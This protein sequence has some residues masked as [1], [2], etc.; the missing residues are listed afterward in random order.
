MKVSEVAARLE[1]LGSSFEQFQAAHKTG[2]EAGQD[3]EEFNTNLFQTIAEKSTFKE[4]L[5]DSFAW[6]RTEEGGVYW[7][8]IKNGNKP[9]QV[10]ASPDEAVPDYRVESL[11]DNV[12][13]G[14]QILEPRHQRKLIEVLTKHLEGVK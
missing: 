8:A 11:G 14:C 5:M 9:P 12:K 2:V 1:E 7:S 10:I 13:V 3:I 4:V 6:S